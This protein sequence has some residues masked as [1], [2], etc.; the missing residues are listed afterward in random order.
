MFLKNGNRN[1]TIKLIQ[2]TTKT[3]ISEPTLSEKCHTSP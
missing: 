1:N 2:I 3:L